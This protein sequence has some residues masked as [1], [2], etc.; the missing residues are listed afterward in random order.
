MVYFFAQNSKAKEF[1]STTL[2]FSS[3]FFK[4]IFLGNFIQIFARFDFRLHL[5]LN[6][7]GCRFSAGKLKKFSYEIS[8]RFCHD[9]KIHSQFVRWSVRVGLRAGALH[10]IMGN[11]VLAVLIAPIWDFNRYGA[12][13]DRVSIVK[14]RYRAFY[15][16]IMLLS[17]C[18]PKRPGARM[19]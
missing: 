2:S 13:A 10:A 3:Q 14:M 17:M 6:P 7:P 4:N 9:F 18:K 11:A 16:L 5:I 15:T 12:I 19:A 1:E 8:L